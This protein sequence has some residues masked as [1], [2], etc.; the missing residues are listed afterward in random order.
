VYEPW[1][2]KLFV[3]YSTRESERFR[4]FRLPESRIH[5]ALFIGAG[6]AQLQISGAQLRLWA[7]P[8]PGHD[9]E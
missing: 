1:I 7:V 4:F 6:R 9:A 3:N 8:F 2:G 5:L